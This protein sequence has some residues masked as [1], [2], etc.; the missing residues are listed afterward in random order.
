[1]VIVIEGE[2]QRKGGDEEGKVYGEK[3]ENNNDVKKNDNNKKQL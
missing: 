1:V 3:R 2:G